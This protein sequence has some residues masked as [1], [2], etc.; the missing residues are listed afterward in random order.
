M[1]PLNPSPDITAAEFYEK[2]CRDLAYCAPEVMATRARDLFSQTYQ[3]AREEG[4]LKTASVASKAMSNLRACTQ[5]YSVHEK[6]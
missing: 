4:D 3:K 2:G 1:T 6:K 5:D